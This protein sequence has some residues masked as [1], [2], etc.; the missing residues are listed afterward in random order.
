MASKSWRMVFEYLS[1]YKILD[2]SVRLTRVSLL[3]GFLGLCPSCPKCQTGES[4]QTYQDPRAIGI[5]R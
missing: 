3:C 1:V 4:C 5:V 2:S